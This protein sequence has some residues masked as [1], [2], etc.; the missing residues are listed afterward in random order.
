MPSHTLIR[1]YRLDSTLSHAR[2]NL[3]DLGA[4]GRGFIIPEDPSESVHAFHLARLRNIKAPTFA[5]A[6]LHEGDVVE[7]QLNEQQQVEFLRRLAVKL[8]Q[9]KAA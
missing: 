6:G 8:P 4:D 7:F 1:S 5:A 3:T 9:R 2:G